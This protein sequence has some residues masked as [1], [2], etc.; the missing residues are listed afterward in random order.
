MTS[1]DIP[2]STAAP[3]SHASNTEHSAETP[4]SNP[5]AP[6]YDAAPPI[7]SENARAEQP[8]EHTSNTEVP[9]EH[10]PHA[11]V[12]EITP[13]LPERPQAATTADATAERVSPEVESLKAMF[14]DFDVLIL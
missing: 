10:L 6:P 3:D 5:V 13:A 4:S 1:T 8:I 7:A 9:T 2:D 14:P 12:E 11:S